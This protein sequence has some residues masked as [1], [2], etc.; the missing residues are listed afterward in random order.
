MSALAPFRVA[1]STALVTG[2][3]GGMGEQLA[4]GLARRGADVIIVDRDEVGLGRVA[5]ELTDRHPERRISHLLVD[6]ADPRAGKTM[7]DSV[8]DGHPGLNLIFNNAGVA[9]A[10]RFDEL[11]TAEFDWLLEINL[12][13]PIRIIRGLLPLLTENAKLDGNAHIVNTSSVFG[14]LGPYGQSAYATSKFGLR[15]FSESLGHELAG[16]GIGV[17]CVLPGGIRTN[18]ATNARIAAGMRR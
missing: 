6:L 15:G 14:L 5:A 2:A 7:I 18:I 11:S 10:G 8:R 12:R 17:T 9:L 16:V 1:G 4:H 3:A 13:A